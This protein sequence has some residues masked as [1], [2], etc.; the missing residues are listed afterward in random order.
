L[1]IRHSFMLFF[2]VLIHVFK[3]LNAG[4]GG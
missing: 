3:T 1:K 2:L 4:V